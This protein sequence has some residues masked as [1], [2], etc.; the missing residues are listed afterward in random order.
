MGRV[1]VWGAECGWGRGCPLLGDC[2]LP[3]GATL[4]GGW[5]QG[6]VRVRFSDGL[7]CTVTMTMGMTGRERSS[8]LHPLH[9]QANGSPVMNEKS[10]NFPLMAVFVC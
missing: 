3:W 9:R 6:Q 8:V 10:S 2:G 1:L 4:R 7:W 5:K